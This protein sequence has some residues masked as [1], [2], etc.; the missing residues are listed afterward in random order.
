RI[1]ALGKQA[2]ERIDA[3]VYLLTDNRPNLLPDGN[4]AGYTIEREVD[5]PKPLL[6]DLHSDKGMSW[7]PTSG[8]TFTHLVV[9]AD[10]PKLRYDLASA[11]TGQPSRERAGLAPLP[12]PVPTPVPTPTPSP[13]PVP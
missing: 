10:A 3:D 8:M 2:T 4:V 1:L 11:E 7:L 9:G 12:T 13:T 6:Q 5:A